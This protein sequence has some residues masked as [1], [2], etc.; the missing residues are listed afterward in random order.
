MKIFAAAF[1][2]RRARSP[3]LTSQQKQFWMET[4]FSCLARA[5]DCKEGRQAGSWM[6]LMKIMICKKFLLKINLM[7]NHSLCSS[8][9]ISSAFYF[10][11]YFLPNEASNGE[12]RVENII[13]NGFLFSFSFFLHRLWSCSLSFVFWLSST[14]FRVEEL[15]YGH[16]FN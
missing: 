5:M 1:C 8:H 13:L 11:F 7:S 12:K 6:I 16:E 10:H 14:R 3:P 15:I 9:Y 4:H 2:A